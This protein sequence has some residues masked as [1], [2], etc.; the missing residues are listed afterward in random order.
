V[1]ERFGPIYGL[2]NN[3]GLGT[4]GIL[5]TMP[6]SSI[7]KLVELNTL[8]PIVLTKYAVRSMMNEGAGANR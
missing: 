4:E 2:I 1:R 6:E 3:A 5:A 8:A 7:E